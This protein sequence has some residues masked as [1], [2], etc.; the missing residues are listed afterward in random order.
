MKHSAILLFLFPLAPLALGQAVP[1]ARGPAFYTGWHLPDVSGTLN[2]SLT[3]SERLRLGASNSINN[4]DTFDISGNVGYLS[5]STRHPFSAVYSGGYLVEESGNIPSSVF[6]ALSLSQILEFGRWK[7]IVAD[8]VNYTPETPA[9]GLSG[10]PGIGDLNVPPVTDTQDILSNE[11]QRV[12]N[13][14]SGTVE[15]EL[16]GATNLSGTGS[17]T[18]IRYLNVPGGSGVDGDGYSGSAN[19]EHTFDVRTSAGLRYSYSTFSYVSVSYGITTQTAGIQFRRQLSR[20]AS[21]SAFAGP[22]HIASS[23]PAL[24]PSRTDFSGNAALSYVTRDLTT[25]LSVSQ[26]ANAGSGLVAGVNAT[27][28]HL[29]A[30]RQF[31]QAWH[32]SVDAGYLRATSLQTGAY[33]AQSAI[34]GAQANR[35][36]LRHL[37]GF[38]SY[39][40]EHQIN[41]GS[42]IPTLALNGFIQTLA[43][44]VTYAPEPI[45]LGH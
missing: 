36:I 17:Q 26:G 3:A 12:L 8:S 40:L 20:R 45:H 38:I 5:A 22:Q 33:T 23:E 21:L 41:E 29:S 44:G 2:Y 37:S 35:S 24:I 31:G 14:L 30:S 19:L 34:F 32:T 10:I 25:T 9:G 7:F 4:G 15:R 18:I 42:N 43:F 6:Q 39:T 1:A 11:A 28:V 27:S 13:S 16:T